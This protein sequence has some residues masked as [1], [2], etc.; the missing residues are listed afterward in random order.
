MCPEPPLSA[1]LLLEALKTIGIQF[2]KDE[3]SRIDET[4]RS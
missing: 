4:P 2:L 1:T 3:C